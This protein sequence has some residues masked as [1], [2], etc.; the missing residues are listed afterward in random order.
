VG[1][2]VHMLVRGAGLA[3]SMSRYLIH[4]I[5]ET[6]NI[7]LKTNTRLEALEG[8]ASLERVTWRDTVTGERTTS[9]IGHVFLMTGALPN[10]GWL[11][12]CVVV[13]EKGFVKTGQDISAEE[14][15]GAKWP[16]ARSPLLFET[17]RPAVF[18]VGDVRAMSVKR[19]AAAVGE[20]SVAVQLVHR[21][22]AE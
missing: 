3:E 20:G 12:G 7:E 19:V 22:L 21:V 11:A 10:T 17:S 15:A 6:S 8:G 1:R 18:A 13:D 16:L 5:E 9:G 4:R 14:L 2:R